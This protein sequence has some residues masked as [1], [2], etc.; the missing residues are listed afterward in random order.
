MDS[1]DIRPI[2]LKH[3]FNSIGGAERG[4]PFSLLLEEPLNLLKICSEGLGD[5]L[6]Q[7]W[8]IW[9]DCSENENILYIAPP[10]LPPSSLN[11][12]VFQSHKHNLES[13]PVIP[14]QAY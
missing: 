12:G 10:S 9:K 6:R 1:I 8:G 7:T 13:H 2:I 14:L 5:A 11:H 3:H 4:V